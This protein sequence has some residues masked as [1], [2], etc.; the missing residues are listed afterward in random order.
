MI[1]KK[2]F[3]LIKKG[4]LDSAQKLISSLK[5]KTQKILNLQGLIH[6]KKKDLLKAINA[7]NE[8]ISLDNQFAEPLVNLG[9]IFFNEK[10][11]DLAKLN[12][13]KALKINKNLG[14]C[15]FYLGQIAILVEQDVI[16]AESFF[17]ESVKLESKNFFFLNN[18]GIFYFTNSRYLDAIKVFKKLKNFDHKVDLDILIGK[19]Y[20]NLN[21]ISESIKV[22]N[23]ILKNNPNHEEANYLQYLN[24]SYIGSYEESLE[25]LAKVLKLSPNNSKA[26]LSLSNID[27]KKCMEKLNEI[28]YFFDQEKIDVKKSELGFCLFNLFNYKRDFKKA[29]FYLKQAND[30]VFKNINL[31][32]F[33]DQKE[34]SIYKEVFT[35]ATIKKYSHNDESLKFR[36]IFIVGMPRSGSSLVEHILGYYKEIDNLGEVDYLFRAIKA[37]YKKLDLNN[38]S[39]KILNSLLSDVDAKQIRNIYFKHVSPQSYYFTDKMLT[40]FRFIG[41]IKYCFP[42]AKILYCKRNKNDNCFSIFSNHLGRLPLPWIYN[43]NM[44]TKYYDL[45]SELMDHWIRIYGDDIFTI[46]YENFVTNYK[47]EAKKIVEF[48]GIEWNELCLDT[49][50]NFSV[51]KTAS[52]NQVRSNIYSNHLNYSNNYRKYLPDLF[53]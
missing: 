24:Y 6:S 19:A 46:D 45:H 10:K 34:L 33:D 41:F 14:I 53:H 49:K 22:F 26:L 1:D 35:E 42:N 29:S 28:T 37:F 52:Y 12:F 17:L 21:Q 3:L 27:K 2:I 31:K 7:F 47:V 8:S 50:L 23:K 15:Y 51:V 48:I 43:E 13:G 38:F 4:E 36:P 40:N 18:L 30:L 11:Y 44:L 39:N 32:Q 9:L 25:Y 16:L 5:N 20:Q